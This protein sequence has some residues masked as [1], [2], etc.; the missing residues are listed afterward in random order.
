MT[1]QKTA[2]MNSFNVDIYGKEVPSTVNQ[3]VNLLRVV[4]KKDP[5]RPLDNKARSKRT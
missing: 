1:S 2:F 5:E 4:K 3:N